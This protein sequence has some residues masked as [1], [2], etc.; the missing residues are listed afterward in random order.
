LDL[1]YSITTAN[2]HQRNSKG[3]SDV[4]KAMRVNIKFILIFKPF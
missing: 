2:M 3:L 1:Q 4:V